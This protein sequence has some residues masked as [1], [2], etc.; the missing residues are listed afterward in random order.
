MELVADESLLKASWQIAEIKFSDPWYRALAKDHIGY[1]LTNVH[2]L[3][4]PQ[5]FDMW[6]CLTVC[7]LGQD[8]QKSCGFGTDL[9]HWASLLDPTKCEKSFAS[10]TSS[11]NGVVLSR[12]SSLVIE[13]LIE[14]GNN[15]SFLW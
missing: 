4:S 14:M 3:I 12:T 10:L 13:R 9:H 11:R 6:T 8:V 2:P 15:H 7:A 5:Y 1:L